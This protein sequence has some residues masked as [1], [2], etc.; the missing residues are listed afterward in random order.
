MLLWIRFVV[1]RCGGRGVVKARFV[2]GER[3]RE[4]EWKVEAL[5]VQRGAE[6]RRLPRAE[7]TPVRYSTRIYLTQLKSVISF[8]LWF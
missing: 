3:S 7:N 1:T 6:S 4:G 2:N 5:V 8:E